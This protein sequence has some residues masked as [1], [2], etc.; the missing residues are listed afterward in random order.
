MAILP[1][2]RWFLSL[3]NCTY[4]FYK[5]PYGFSLVFLWEGENGMALGEKQISLPEVD[6]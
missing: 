5:S 1:V 6:G 3:I 2:V 4:G